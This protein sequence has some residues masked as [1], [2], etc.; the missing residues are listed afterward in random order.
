MEHRRDRGEGDV[1]DIGKGA[2]SE[3]STYFK[4]RYVFFPVFYSIV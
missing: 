1:P 4:V 2:F 3:F